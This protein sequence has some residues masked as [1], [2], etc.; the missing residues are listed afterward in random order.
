M[1]D[2]L[3]DRL[4]GVCGDYSQQQSKFNDDTAAMQRLHGVLGGIAADGEVDSD[5]VGHLEQWLGEHRFLAGLWPYDEVDS[6]ITSFAKSDEVAEQQQD[7]MM[8]VCREFVFGP[9]AQLILE[10]MEEMAKSGVCSACPSIKFPGSGFCI[11]GH[12]SRGRK[13]DLEADIVRLGGEVEK[14]VTK[15]VDY[16]VVGAKG[17]GAWAFNC[18]GRKVERAMMMRKDGHRLVLVHEFDFWDAVEDA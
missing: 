4:L 2:S 10:N 9:A 3:R 17:N 12:P 14:G 6:L 18:Y 11:T 15:S 13:A 1:S 8:A 5:E 7:F 16:L